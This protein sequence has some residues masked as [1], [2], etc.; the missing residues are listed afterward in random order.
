MCKNKIGIV[1]KKYKYF[2]EKST[3]S[4]R[5]NDADFSV[6]NFSEI[7]EKIFCQKSFR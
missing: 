4:W 2:V 7:L 1:K 3:S 6:E 5:L